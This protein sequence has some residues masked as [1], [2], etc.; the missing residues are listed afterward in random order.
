M[1]QM[2]MVIKDEYRVLFESNQNV[3]DSD[4]IILNSNENYS[5]VRIYRRTNFILGVQ[6]VVLTWLVIIAPASL[7]YKTRKKNCSLTKI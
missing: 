1:I 7:I 3:F 6:N 5:N 2:Y 4:K